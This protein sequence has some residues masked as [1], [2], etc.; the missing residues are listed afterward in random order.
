MGN[1]VHIH[2]SFRDEEGNP[3]THDDSD[4]HGMSAL[5]GSFIAGVLK[6]LDSIVALTAPVSHF[7]SAAYT[8]SLERCFQQSR[9]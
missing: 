6:Y 8:P 2:L 4:P 3:T 5:S 9:I 7:L 1:G